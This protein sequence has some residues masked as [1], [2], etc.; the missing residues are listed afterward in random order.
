MPYYIIIVINILGLVKRCTHCYYGQ[1]LGNNCIINIFERFMRWFLIYIAQQL[2]ASVILI[3]NSHTNRKVLGVSYLTQE[4][5]LSA[6]S[7]TDN[8]PV[9]QNDRPTPNQPATE[10]PQP[11]SDITSPPAETQQNASENSETETPVEQQ[12]QSSG[13]EN[14]EQITPELQNTGQSING[15]VGKKP[16]KS[17]LQS[18]LPQSVFSPEETLT[19]SENVNQDSINEA[20]K[21]NEQLQKTLAPEQQSILLLGF[22]ADK[23]GDIDKFLRTND[24]ASTNFA[25]LRLTEEITKIQS[26][27]QRVSVLKKQ[28]LSNQLK[29]LCSRADETLRSAEISVPEQSEQDIEITRGVCLNNQ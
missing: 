8:S 28:E 18:D 3:T 12:G 23:V 7:S 10:T 25:T 26:V 27:L 11:P 1:H 2:A 16:E 17:L 4:G 22:A 15:N 6:P 19:S 9:P 24:F 21:E 14:A 29:N 13:S 20:E 5:D